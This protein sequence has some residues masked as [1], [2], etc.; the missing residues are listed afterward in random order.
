MLDFCVRV[1]SLACAICISCAQ[2]YVKLTF[3]LTDLPVSRTS[4]VKQ[5]HLAV[6]VGKREP[7]LVVS[8]PETSCMV[9][10]WS[11]DERM[12]ALHCVHQGREAMRVFGV[13]AREVIYKS[14]AGFLHFF[15][16][17]L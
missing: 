2:V 12:L 4:S 8:T 15:A 11:P 10:T 14:P 5:L 1:G 16:C 6:Q 7:I 17:L 13:Q 3:K 9:P